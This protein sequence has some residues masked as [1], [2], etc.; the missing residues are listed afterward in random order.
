MFIGLLIGIS[1]LLTSCSCESNKLKEGYSRDVLDMQGYE[2]DVPPG[3]QCKGG[4]TDGYR[5]LNAECLPDRGDFEITV[6]RGLTAT[7]IGD[8]DFTEYMIKS[9]SREFTGSNEK[10]VCENL[11]PD[12]LSL[13]AQDYLC[14]HSIDNMPTVTIG[15][16]NSYDGVARWFESHLKVDDD[17]DIR[18]YIDVLSKFLDEG[19]K[20]DWSDY[21]I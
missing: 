21:R 4:F 7:S 13:G 16:G 15:I 8:D 12:R 17:K 18:D 19:I 9:R 6:E 14:I 5:Y 1:L 20:I 10:I 3:F 11:D 2:L